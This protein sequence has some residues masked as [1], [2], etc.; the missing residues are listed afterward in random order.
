MVRWRWLAAVAV[1]SSVMPA[2]AAAAILT[3][4]SG[5]LRA[6]L[7]TN[8]WRLRFQQSGGPALTELSGTSAS[9]YGTLGFGAHPVPRWGG[10]PSPP[11]GKSWWHATRVL[12]ARRSGA[13]L[14]LVLA[15]NDP[16]GRR[17]EVSLAPAG[18]GVIAVQARV[19]GNAAGVTQMSDS[20]ASGTGEHFS[21]FGG[22]E[23]RVD[24]AGQTVENW[25]E[26]GAWIPTD[27]PVI[28]SF[29]EPWTDSN[30]ADGAYFPMPWLV[31]S[32]GYGFLLDDTVRSLFRLRSDRRTAWDVEADSARLDYRVFAG[33]QPLDVVRRM[34]G[35]V[36]RQP[37]PAAPWVLGPWWQPTGPNADSLPRRFRRLD[38]PGSLIMTYTHYLPCGSQR[39]HAASERA[40]AAALHA[41]GYAVTTYFNPMICS[42]Y[43]PVFSRAQ[44]A[45][46]LLENRRGQPYPI[47]YNQY[48]VAEVDFTT[49]AG[50]RLYHRLLQ[51]AVSNGYDGWMED[52]GEYTPPDSRAHDGTP[53]TA[54]HNLY[55]RLYHCAAYAFTSHERRPVIE[56]DRSG[57]TGSARCSPVVWSGDPTTDWGFDGLPGMVTQGISYGYSGVG[58]YGSD[59][60]GYFSITAPPTT[61][62]LLA[63]WLE[64]GAFSGVM[65]TESEGLTVSPGTRAQIWDPQ[66]EPIWRRYAKLRTQ[67]Y[68][69]VAAAAA[70][71]ETAGI[72]LIEALGLAYPHD[73]SSWEGPPRYLFGPNLL[74]APVTRPGVRSIATPLPPGRWL[75]LW[76]AVSYEGRSGSFRLRAARLLRGRATVTAP[77]DEIP[78]FVRSGTLLALTAP[79]V[80]TLARYGR[81][82]V[83]LADRARRLHVLAWPSSTSST[84]ALGTRLRSTLTSR[85]WTLRVSGVV[86]ARLDLEA[87]LPGCI[88][89]LTWR[90]HALAAGR[91]SH[92]GGVLRVTVRGDGTLAAARSCER[93][94][95]P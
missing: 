18:A 37:A 90:G 22:R 67:L 26:E 13:V 1:L 34:S 21:G 9:P 83:H 62:E 33:P 92:R 44:S 54:L 39:G 58:F 28:P 7:S 2:S 68:P 63:R 40:R 91:F 66:V 56:F 10:A 41:A 73:R 4:R 20:F 59:I 16:R 27:R 69:Y 87:D 80:A 49:A 8:P 31:S 35:A 82:V 51:E 65:R 17:L 86:P 19:L 74:V 70:R 38:V 45:G 36:G 93:A 61:P 95:H 48:S 77:L 12:S 23:N 50:R 3:V 30:R 29:I 46:A 89:R 94:R 52:F 42:S 24:Q 57:W 6:E 79:D 25:S 88:S 64:F 32:R 14:R 72:P 75:S 78:A 55:P 53:G 60:G 5:T 76:Q 43:Q 47:H 71:Y 11:P 84:V 15:T 81:G 85:L